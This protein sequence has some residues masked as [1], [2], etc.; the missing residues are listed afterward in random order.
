M[1]AKTALL[2][3]IVAG[4][5][6]LPETGR[7][8]DPTQPHEGY[9]DLVNVG[10]DGWVSIEGSDLTDWVPYDTGDGGIL[11]V[12]DGSRFQWTQ[13]VDGVL[14]LRLIEGEI[15][16][17]G[18]A[19]IEV[20]GPE[21]TTAVGSG[22]AA[23]VENGRLTGAATTEGEVRVTATDGES[24][25]VRGGETFNMTGAGLVVVP[26]TDETRRAAAP[27]EPQGPAD[28]DDSIL[29]EMD[30]DRP[31][32][33]RDETDE[34]AAGADTAPR[35]T[36]A[37]DAQE[38]ERFDPEAYEAYNDAPSW[39]TVEDDGTV[40]VGQIPVIYAEDIQS[41]VNWIDY[42]LGE[43]VLRV[44][45]HSRIRVEE[46]DFGTKR[47]I[48]MKG[49]VTYFG[50]GEPPIQVVHEETGATVSGINFLVGLTEEEGLTGWIFGENGRAL[51]DTPG[52]G[53]RTLSGGDRFVVGEAGIEILEPADSAT[54][55]ARDA[56]PD[57]DD[58]LADMSP[59][60][61]ARL[62]RNVEAI[63]EQL[64]REF[65]DDYPEPDED[66]SGEGV[67]TGDREDGQEEQP[68]DF[69]DR[70]YS[71]DG[72][73]N[74][75]FSD[76]PAEDETV[77]TAGVEQVG[78]L[79]G[80][81]LY[82]ALSNT[83]LAEDETVRTTGEFQA[84]GNSVS[85]RLDI[86]SFYRN[87]GTPS[88][89]CLGIARG[90]ITVDVA[91]DGEPFTVELGDVTL[92]VT[93]GSAAHVVATDFG[94]GGS[95]YAGKVNVS[96][97]DGQ[98]QSFDD[99]ENILS[100]SAA[101]AEIE[102]AAQGIDLESIPSARDPFLRNPLPSSGWESMDEFAPSAPAYSDTG[103]DPNTRPW[104][105][106]EPVAPLDVFGRVRDTTGRVVNTARD[107]GS[108]ADVDSVSVSEG[109]DSL[110][111]FDTANRDD[112]YANKASLDEGGVKTPDP[113]IQ[114][115]FD[116]ANRDAFAAGETRNLAGD[117]VEVAT[118]LA[119]LFE[120][121]DPGDTGDDTDTGDDMDTG[122]PEPDPE[123]EPEP[124]PGDDTGT[125]DDTDTGD[126][127]GMDD[128]PPP[129]GDMDDAF[130]ALDPSLALSLIF[131]AP[132]AD[133]P[134]EV[135]TLSVAN[136]EGL[137]FTVDGSG[138][139]TGFTFPLPELP[140]LG[141]GDADVAELS[142]AN[143]WQVL[144]WT[145]G[146]PAEEIGGDIGLLGPDQGVHI[147]LIP[148][149]VD[150][151]SGGTASYDLRG[152]TGPTYADGETAPGTFDGA[153]GVAF[154]GPSTKV[155]IEA[156]VTMPDATYGFTTTGGAADPSAATPI[157]SQFNPTNGDV[158]FDNLSTE[159]PMGAT[160]CPAGDC[161][162]DAQFRFGGEGADFLGGV[163]VIQG[164]DDG[165][166]LSGAA[167]FGKQ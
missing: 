108:R 11:L 96:S 13:D 30:F 63:R 88:D 19:P 56:A 153:M 23:G 79:I 80:K 117:P 102:R 22:L 121:V 76:L 150:V 155:G 72:L 77:R 26:A 37:Q 137:E 93:P 50:E 152:A 104:E 24:G 74:F 42:S 44:W 61:R 15:N 29:N 145:T 141:I 70:D 120:D 92:V 101:A 135:F 33:P 119:D 97:S 16:Y 123:P 10:E 89:S 149:F 106:L 36:D 38:T 43:N 8:F 113:L 110:F 86:G 131:V 3:M 21:G 111:E 25:I 115:E 49:R 69:W 129:G 94:I 95:V 35:T 67:P 138:A 28:P 75:S 52:A 84:L 100:A 125:G 134:G 27:D 122:Q 127:T 126:D 14:R 163:F 65:P 4:M 161:E 6:V 20:T 78:S 82:A 146:T 143:N 58:P 109:L 64:A 45:E 144:R 60:E 68:R 66:A 162:T 148:T 158:L 128:M 107:V 139:F 40:A 103:F 1:T 87:C 133:T 54:N 90:G 5:I 136:G 51:V 55:T 105:K 147:A 114:F 166:A 132:F 99:P 85:L 12:R 53:S 71:L 73:F 9:A 164:V 18:P 62:E 7:A 39:V 83:E 154:D 31:D 48:I 59:Y 159:A 81:R 34:A 130:A 32:K 2:S 140:D 118:A 112:Y 98:T 47:V 167:V 124:D 157:E 156:T 160:A 41:S 57:T 46:T 142:G 17:H 165:S 91:E 151:P 116:T